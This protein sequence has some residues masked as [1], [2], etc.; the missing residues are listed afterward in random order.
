[1]RRTLARGDG[2]HERG[3]DLLKRHHALERCG[4]FRRA[5]PTPQAR[6]WFARGCQCWRFD[7]LMRLFGPWAFLHL[8]LRPF[9]ALFVVCEFDR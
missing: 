6:R 2:P 7:R 8:V 3:R 1:V 4:G 5:V 9:G